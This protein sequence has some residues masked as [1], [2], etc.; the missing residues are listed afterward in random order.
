MLKIIIII[1]STPLALAFTSL[2]V[3]SG[4]DLIS[5][6]DVQCEPLGEEPISCKELEKCEKKPITCVDEKPSVVGDVEAV[7]SV[8]GLL[9]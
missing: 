1:G 7:G 9:G 6:R 3:K 4:T 5:K 2:D 8:A